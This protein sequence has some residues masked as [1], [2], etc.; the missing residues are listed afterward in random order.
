MKKIL[1]M[2]LCM[3]TCGAALFAQDRPFSIG[4]GSMLSQNFQTIKLKN[5]DE[6]KFFSLRFG[7]VAFVDMRYLEFSVAFVYPEITEGFDFSTHD[8]I[9]N[10]NVKFPVSI[11]ERFELFPFFGTDYRKNIIKGKENRADAEKSANDFDALSAILGGGA[12][13]HINDRIY[14]RA[15]AGLGFTFSTSDE[16]DKRDNIDSNFKSKVS[17]KLMTGIKL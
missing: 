3:T 12:D 8:V 14:L 5:A 6:Q 13:F 10:L 16:Y 4:I 15:E 17:V 1:V 9:F 2:I 11:T 7:T